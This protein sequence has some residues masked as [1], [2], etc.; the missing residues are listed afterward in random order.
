MTPEGY[1]YARWKADRQRLLSVQF[2]PDGNVR[3]VIFKPNPKHKN[4][5]VR[6]SGLTTSDSLI[7]EILNHHISDWVLEAPHRR[8]RARAAA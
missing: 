1:I 2:L 8:S 4:V 3:L 5:I 6:F 7:D